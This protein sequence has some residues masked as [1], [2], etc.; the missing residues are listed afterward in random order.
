VPLAAAS[1]LGQVSSGGRYQSAGRTL[2][3]RWSSSVSSLDDDLKIWD[4]E[5]AYELEDWDLADKSETD[6]GTY[7]WAEETYTF[8][9]GS[10]S[11]WAGGNVLTATAA[12]KY[13]D[14]LDTWMVYSWV[15]PSA[16]I[17]LDLYLL[18]DW[19][20]DAEPGDALTVLTSEDGETFT[21][22]WTRSDLKGGWRRNEQISLGT[23]AHQGRFYIAFR[24]TSDADGQAGLGAFVDYIRLRG[25][26]LMHL[27]Y[28]PAIFRRWPPLPVAPVL[29]EIDKIPEAENYTV[30]WHPPV[31]GSPIIS[32]TLQ[33][34]TEPSFDTYVDYTSDITAYTMSDKAH[35]LYYYRVR[36]YNSWG[37]G[38]WSNVVSTT[39]KPPT[40]E[41]PLLQEID[42][43]P[44]VEDYTVEWHPPVF[45]GPIVSYT[46]QES[47]SLDFSTAIDYTSKITAY[48]MSDQEPGQYHYRVRAYNGWEFGP[49]SN[50]V[51]TTVELSAFRDDFSDPTSG[52]RARRTSSPDLDLIK[53]YY[54]DGRLITSIEDRFD[55]GIYSPMQEA[56]PLP[57]RI[58]LQT[59]IINKANLVS[60]GIVFGANGG[61]FCSIDRE[62]AGDSNGCF[63]HYYRMNAVWGGDYFKYGLKR[64]DHH[65]GGEDGRGKGR[66]VDLVP[67]RR[68]EDWRAHPNSWNNWQILVYEDGFSVY[69][70][71]Q[72]L[73]WTYE[74]RYVRD[75]FWGIF[76][77]TDEYNIS[78][79]E[80]DY[81]YV[82]PIPP[83]E[84]PPSLPSSDEGYC[85]SDVNW[86]V[87]LSRASLYDMD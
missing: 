57:Y 33:E 46:L 6:G 65:Q 79:W 31:F 60:Y 5:E 59:Q 7:L 84:M 61:T 20:L 48:T 76:S 43:P 23:V 70:N 45:D 9:H 74:S 28:L 82:E 37:L 1:T 50:V 3:A 86:C 19:W 41:A 25:G 11:V 49:W 58:V 66:G 38:P 73:G 14:N 85:L 39:V 87:P 72:H 8:T 51:T 77:S 36:A 32:Y 2:S 12:A 64:I 75:P 17:G 4:F 21:P 68:L 80:H 44:E 56:P 29:Q 62:L 81:F 67:Y 40:P 71:G 63:Y 69:V 42:K 30:A 78:R 15:I 34:A 10:Q 55:F 54:S 18:F 83:G 13:P 35:G 47:T 27:V 26:R 24:F 22:V 53:S 16:S 52:W